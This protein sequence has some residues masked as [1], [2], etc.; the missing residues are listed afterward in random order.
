MEITETITIYDHTYRE[1]I[2][3]EAQLEAII[4]LARSNVALTTDTILTIVGE[5]KDIN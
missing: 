4:R 2:R 1:L 5:K 3:K